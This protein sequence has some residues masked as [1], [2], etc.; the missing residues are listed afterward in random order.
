[1]LLLFLAIDCISDRNSVLED[2]KQNSE[3][4]FYVPQCTPD[5]RYSKVQCY[6]GYCWCVYQ[7]TGKPIPG[8][9]IKDGSPNCNPVPEPNRPMKGGRRLLKIYNLNLNKKKKKKIFFS[10]HIFNAG[11]P[12]LK[13][14]AFLRDLM[15]LMQK[16]MK[17]SSTESDETTLKWQTS[18]EERVATWHFVML[19]RNKNKVSCC[20][21]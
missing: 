7:D 5:G 14:Q 18:N 16:K 11:C 2:Q 6:S 3:S 13:K 9:S 19:D 4:K 17:S 20:F 10:P 12:E 15:D 8:T 1:M 21:P